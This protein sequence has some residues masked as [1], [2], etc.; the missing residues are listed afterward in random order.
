MKRTTASIGQRSIYP[1]AMR[2]A[3]VADYKKMDS[4]QVATNY[5]ISKGTVCRWAAA[6]K[7]SKP[8]PAQLAAHQKAAAAIKTYNTPRLMINGQHFDTMKVAPEPKDATHIDFRGTI[9]IV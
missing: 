1:R 8:Q 2:V 9:Y 4:S 3:V 6:D 7:K 5:N